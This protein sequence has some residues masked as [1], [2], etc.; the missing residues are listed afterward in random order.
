MNRVVLDRANKAFVQAGTGLPDSNTRGNVYLDLATSTLYVRVDPDDPW[1]EISG[2][3]GDSFWSRDET[4]DYLRPVTTTDTVMVGDGDAAHPAIEFGNTSSGFYY[5]SV[6]KRINIGVDANLKAYFDEEGLNF[7]GSSS[8]SGCATAHN[9]DVDTGTEPVDTFIP[10]ADGACT[11]HYFVGQGTNIRSGILTCAWDLSEED[12]TFTE[13]ASPSLGDTSDLTFD[14]AFSTGLLTLS[15]T[16][17]S[18][19]W[20]VKVFR[21]RVQ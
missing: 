21:L 7:P 18:D 1:T 20:S 17:I 19:N 6:L 8:V 11:W 5:D 14:I 3:G 16:A 15:A 4:N 10:T 12:V 9:T 13:I 2:G